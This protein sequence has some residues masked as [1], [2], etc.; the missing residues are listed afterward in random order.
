[1]LTFWELQSTVKVLDSLASYTIYWD[2]CSC[3]NCNEYH[4]DSIVCD[5]CNY[6]IYAKGKIL[7]SDVEDDG[8]I[9]QIIRKEYDNICPN[10]KSKFYTK[11]EREYFLNK[12]MLK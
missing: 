7:F 6:D 10:C 2:Y 9:A 8:D 5:S 4:I 11:E 1:M 12:Y 3:P